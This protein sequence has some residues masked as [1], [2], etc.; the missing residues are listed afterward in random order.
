MGKNKMGK[1]LRT[2]PRKKS[3]IKVKKRKNVARGKTGY[4][5]GKKKKKI[6]KERGGERDTTRR[7]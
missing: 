2:K 5:E 7:M 4:F 1:S 6:K 3:I